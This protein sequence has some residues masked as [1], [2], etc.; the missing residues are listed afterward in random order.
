MASSLL[1]RWRLALRADA[2]SP[3]TAKVTAAIRSHTFSLR[4]SSRVTIVATSLLSVA[5]S[6]ARL[7][8]LSASTLPAAILHWCQSAA[9]SSRSSW[10]AFI[11]IKVVEATLFFKACSRSCQRSLFVL[12]V[13]PPWHILL[14]CSDT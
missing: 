11:L 12:G 10:W 3:A 6:A 13:S 5:A 7:A 4:R 1:A 14:P 8:H 2:G 9:I